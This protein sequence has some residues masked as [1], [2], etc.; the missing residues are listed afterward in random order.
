MDEQIIRRFQTVRIISLYTEYNTAS[1][2]WK[3]KKKIVLCIFIVVET[4]LYSSCLDPFTLSLRDNASRRARQMV[5]W[6]HGWV[7]FSDFDIV[8]H[9]SMEFLAPHRSVTVVKLYFWTPFRFFCF[10]LS[11]VPECFIR[12]TIHDEIAALHHFSVKW[13]A[14]HFLQFQTV[15]ITWSVMKVNFLRKTDG[16][17]KWNIW[18]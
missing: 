9:E 16:G 6:G 18:N 12:A 8:S 5:T 3:V 7:R 1:N 2:I 14:T 13:R 17:K 11:R 4:V 15:I 10:S